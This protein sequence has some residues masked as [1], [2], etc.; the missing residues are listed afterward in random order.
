MRPKTNLLLAI[1]S[2][3]TL[4]SLQYTYGQTIPVTLA[5][6]EKVDHCD[7]YGS[8]GHA[9]FPMTPL[10][11]LRLSGDTAQAVLAS[12]LHLNGGSSYNLAVGVGLDKGIG[13]TYTNKD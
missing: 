11:G 7:W 13:T 4:P 1:S 9:C 6:Y 3:W 8:H 5:P 2:V 12:G 10:R